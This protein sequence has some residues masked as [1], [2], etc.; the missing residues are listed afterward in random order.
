MET[1]QGQGDMDQGGVTQDHQHQHQAPS[2]GPPSM[3]MREDQSV[4]EPLS[5]DADVL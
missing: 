2:M 4:S 5:A 3:W 1:R